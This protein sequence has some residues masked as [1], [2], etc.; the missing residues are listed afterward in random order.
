MATKA[1]DRPTR[2]TRSPSCARRRGPL[3]SDPR[4]GNG[5][6]TS[7]LFTINTIQMPWMQQ[8]SRRGKN[9]T[10]VDHGAGMH[11]LCT[12]MKG[13][14][15]LPTQN[16]PKKKLTPKPP[17]MKRKRCAERATCISH[18]HTGTLAASHGSGPGLT[19][20]VGLDC[21]VFCTRRTAPN[22]SETPC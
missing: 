5:T 20:R 10:D 2:P 1:T 6:A 22:F 19:V 18:A 12:Q 17:K 21:G 3:A 8:Q 9:D 14:C 4:S 15:K 16:E 13:D 7:L 11:W